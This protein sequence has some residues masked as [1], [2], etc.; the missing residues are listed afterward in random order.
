MLEMRLHDAEQRRPGRAWRLK[1]AIEELLKVGFATGVQMA[2]LISHGCP[3]AIP[4]EL[5][6]Q[7]VASS[8]LEQSSLSTT[9][10]VCRSDWMCWL[11][12][13]LCRMSMGSKRSG[14]RRS[15]Q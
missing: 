10:G 12:T 3:A 4:L 2:S 1:L 7:R 11:D 8:Q 13:R 15:Q 9:F 5:R 14:G 6:A